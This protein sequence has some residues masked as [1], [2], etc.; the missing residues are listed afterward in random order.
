MMNYFGYPRNWSNPL[1]I[2]FIDEIDLR[3]TFR[4]GLIDNKNDHD[5]VYKLFNAKFLANLHSNSPRNLL[6]RPS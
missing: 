3:K 4:L 5:D 6:V 2:R 1:I